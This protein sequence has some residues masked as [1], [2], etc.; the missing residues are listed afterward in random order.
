MGRNVIV[1]QLVSV[2]GFVSEPDGGL[3]FF[4]AV[5]DYSGVDRDNLALLDRVDTVLLGRRTYEFFVGYWPTA[6]GELV[7][8]RVN[9]TPKIVYSTTL[10]AAPWG[11]H[12]AATVVA[13]PAAGHLSG[14]LAGPGR[15]V[16]VWGSISLAESLIDAGLVDEL[17]LTVVPVVIG[18]GRTLL[19]ADTR[20][21]R[22]ALLGTTPHDSGLVSLRYRLT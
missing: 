15:D 9:T 17:H 19:T 4:E 22:L 11:E 1:Q 5:S 21:P 18:A 6:E 12:P 16:L 7:A 2:D 3:D 14:L 13:Q 20:R 10:A 8:D